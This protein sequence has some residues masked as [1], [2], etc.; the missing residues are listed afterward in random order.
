[1]KKSIIVLFLIIYCCNN[2][3]SQEGK[4]IMKDYPIKPVSFTMVKVDDTFWAPRIKINREITIPIA[5]KKAEETGR[6]DNFKI[7]GGTKQGKFCTIYPFDDSDVFKNIEG[8]A[9]SLHTYPDPKLE[10]YLDS[11]IEIIGKAQEK[12]GYL[13]T[14]RTIDP[15]HTHEWSGKKRWEKEEDLS[16]ELYNLG[17]LYEAAV[18][19]FQATGKRTL[20]NIALKSADL[21]DKEFGWGKIEKAPGHQVIEMG[22]VKL[23]RVTGDER[24]LKLAKFFIDVRGPNKDTYAQ[25][26]KKFVDQDEAVGHSVRAEYM[27]SGA[28]DVAALTGEE[29]YIKALDKIWE[30]VVYKKLYITGGTGSEG[31]YEGF[32]P[33]Y[34]LPNMSAYCETCAAI[35]NVFWNYRMFLLHGESKYIDVLERTLY[36]GLISG[37]SLSGDR[38]FYPNPLASMGQHKR[39]EW[40]GC[41]CCPVNVT[42]LIPSIPGYVY[43]VKDNS[44]YI[45]LFIQSASDVLINNQKVNII[46][47]S[48]YPWDGNITIEINPDKNINFD[49]LIRIP[50]WA[51][52]EPIPGNLYS[53]A[54]NSGEQVKIMLNGIEQKK[55]LKNGYAII[56]NNWKKG[57]KITLYLPMPV[58]TIKANDKVSA[59]KDKI[60]LQ[61]GPIV[62]C[63]EGI[64]Y[65]EKRVFNLMLNNT[66]DL[67]TEFKKD[68]LNGVQVIKGK[69]KSIIQKNESAT[70]SKDIEFTAIPYYAWANRGSGEMTVWFPTKENDVIPI[71]LPTIASTSKI[72]ASHMTKDLKAI[73]DQYEPKSS[74]DNSVIKY[75]W[76]P[77]KDSRE[78]IQYD[79]SKEEEISSVKVY[80]FEDA[81]DGGCRLPKSWIVYYKSGNEWLP[82]KN[83]TEYSTEINKYSEVKFLKVKTNALKLEVELPKEF[84][85]GI[86]EWIVK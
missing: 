57:D 30:D 64:D 32:G 25:G 85:S 29:A 80:W 62:F 18:A 70:E 41:A 20:L 48:N 67:K 86:Y 45:N 43:A 24:Y 84:S 27:Y 76:W 5:F 15:E 31:G 22:L 3:Y 35:A 16:H 40:F 72:T 60:A 1:M 68:L 21:V 71:P 74:N 47:K 78:W 26:H 83:V 50:G 54:D 28:A 65:P 12:D 79:F 69:I 81:P 73:N 77:K 42:R 34:V 51:G 39:A 36:N 17:H 8:A 33:A 63:S 56:S 13:Y 4:K 9:Y 6:I 11:L 38:F 61:R 23:Y 55:I 53:F 14:N 37:V 58:R 10:L 75:H 2:I 82:V 49:A 59:D 7:A 52:N 66:N 19:H 44:L 46:Q